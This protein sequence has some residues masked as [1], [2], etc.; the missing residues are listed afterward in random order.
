MDNIV[1]FPR[2]K[3]DNVVIEFKVWLGS[4][5]EARR[6]L[7][8]LE[9]TCSV[10]LKLCEKAQTDGEGL[11]LAGLERLFE[12]LATLIARERGIVPACEFARFDPPPG[13]A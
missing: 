11:I 5:D 9:A 1:K 8:C 12:T 2:R 7:E 4:V 13:A 10:G 3:A 6:T